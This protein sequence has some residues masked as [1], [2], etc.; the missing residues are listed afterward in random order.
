[1]LLHGGEA[2]AT[3]METDAAHP[4]AQT[5]GSLANCPIFASPAK[6]NQKCIT[7][8]KHQWKRYRSATVLI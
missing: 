4:A 6:E 3:K 7:C 8:L 5:F 1:M 2:L